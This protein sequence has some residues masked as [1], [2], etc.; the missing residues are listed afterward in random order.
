MLVMAMN[1]QRIVKSIDVFKHQY[2]CLLVILDF[3]SIQPFSF[4]QGMERFNTEIIPWI[5]WIE[6]LC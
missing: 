2:V 4:Y 5:L 3:K 1:A 6:M